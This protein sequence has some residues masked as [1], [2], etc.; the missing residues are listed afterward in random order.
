MENDNIA[1]YINF[2]RKQQ[3]T[4]FGGSREKCNRFIEETLPDVLKMM[5]KYSAE[6]NR[7]WLTGGATM[8]YYQLKEIST[9]IVEYTD[10][11]ENLS[12]LLERPIQSF[13]VG[14]NYWATLQEATV[15]YRDYV[16]NGPKPPIQDEEKIL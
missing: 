8:A 15:A 13:E 3:N 10:F 6:D 4:S 12:R 7:W 14:Q 1:Y 2:I 11:M 16:K 5:D 9:I